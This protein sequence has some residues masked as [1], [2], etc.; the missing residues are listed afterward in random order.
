M[1]FFL[2]GLVALA[3]LALV[4]VRLLRGRITVEGETTSP[5]PSETTTKV[6]EVDAFTITLDIDEKP[7]L[8]VLLAAD[9]AINRMGK[10]TVGDPAGGLFI[11]KTDPAIF[12][13]VRSHLSED[14]LQVLG[15]SFQLQNPR[16]VPCKL[17]L[18]FKFKD[19]T[20]SGLA[21]LYGSE[22]EGVPGDVEDFV[23]TAVRL[24]DPWYENFK[25]TAEGKQ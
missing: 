1:K 17:T 12:E 22:S 20:S 14:M 2:L 16:G 25:R 11:G 18:T 9:G 4:A 6:A 13:A 21:F 15:R 5:A 10:G 19:G 24:T 23:T 3:I 8:F 7:S